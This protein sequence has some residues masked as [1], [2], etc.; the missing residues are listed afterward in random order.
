MT[1]KTRIPELGPLEFKLLRILWKHRSL[2]APQVLESYNGQ[3]KTKLA[4]TT[5][6]TLLGRLTDKGVLTV[7]RD[8][9]PYLFSAAVTR[10]QMLRHRVR[11]F[12]NVFFEGEPLDLA[13]RLVEDTPLS[14]ESVDKLQSVLRERKSRTKTEIT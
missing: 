5:V 6:M 13:I 14:D 8:R 3:A 1:K 9:Q 11:E 12:V 4:Y 2:T 7:S 10:D